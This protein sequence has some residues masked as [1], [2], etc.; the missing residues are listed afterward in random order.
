MIKKIVIVLILLVAILIALFWFGPRTPIDTTI[1]PVS[2]PEDLEAYLKASEARFPDIRPGTEKTIVL[3]DR[4]N[5]AKTDIS[6]VYLH[7]F[8]ASRQETAPLCD[9]V[10]KELQANLFYTRLAGHGR[11]GEAMA[12]ATVNHWL[13]DTVEAITIGRRLGEKI[14]IVGT[15]TGGTL[16]TWAATRETSDDILAYILISPNFGPKNPFAAVITWPWAEFTVPLLLGKTRS[17]EPVNRLHDQ[18][19]TNSYPSISLLPMMGLV[20]LVRNSD[21]STIKKPFLFIFSPKDQVVDPAKTEKVYSRLSSPKKSKVYVE[22]SQDPN[23]HVLVG[24]AISP[25]NTEPIV[26]TIIKF[27]KRVSR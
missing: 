1:R 19:W 20:K 15:S 24:D 16:A 7:G 26:E 9:L 17:W 22:D 8:S 11:D 13:N 10:A 2:L 18:Y 5:K 3:A 25:K 23:Y 6:V 12:G 14:I 4:E 27:I 21:V